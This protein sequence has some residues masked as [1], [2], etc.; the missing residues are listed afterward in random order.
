MWATSIFVALQTVHPEFVYIF[1]SDVLALL[2][3]YFKYILTY[4]EMLKKSKQILT[5]TSS[6]ATCTQSCFTKI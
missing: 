4:F 6:Y 5:R 3:F 1:E 2:T